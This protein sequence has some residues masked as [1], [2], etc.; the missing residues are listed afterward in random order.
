MTL[1]PGGTEIVAVGKRA[2]RH[3]KRQESINDMLVAAALADQ[4]VVRLKGGDPSVFGRS[5][6]EVAVL[7]AHGIS[8][9]ICPGI[10]A[11]SAA[12]ASAGVSLTLRGMVRR[13]RFVTAQAR[14]GQPLD[15]D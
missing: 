8:V 4:R 13:V 1:L 7:A 14:A 3:S 10:T 11:A 15:L 12:V 9:R 2:G 5:A 6:E